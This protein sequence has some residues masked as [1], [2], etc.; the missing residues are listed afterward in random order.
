MYLAAVRGH[1]DALRI[2][3]DSGASVSTKSI[4]VGHIS[5][6]ALQTCLC[7]FEACAAVCRGSCND[8]Y[9][10]ALGRCKHVSIIAASWSHVESVRDLTLALWPK[11]FGG[12]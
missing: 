1:V 2:L 8:E 11:G 5:A 4:K 3:L 6:A 7:M 9:Y 12:L 10:V